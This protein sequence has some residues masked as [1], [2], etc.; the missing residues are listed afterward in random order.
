MKVLR[1]MAVGSVVIG[2]KK[3]FQGINATHQN[4][5]VATP[6]EF[7]NSMKQL[8]TNESENKTIRS[9]NLN[10]VDEHFSKKAISKKYSDF[11]EKVFSSK[12]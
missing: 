8:S 3:A 11:F 5:V 10:F 1:A 9:A 6:F 2:N 7:L 4:P 12:N